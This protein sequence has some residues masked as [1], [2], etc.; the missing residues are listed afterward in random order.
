MRKITKSEYKV[1]LN[2]RKYK[3]RLVRTKHCFYVV[4]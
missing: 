3:N 1:L 2:S 4:D